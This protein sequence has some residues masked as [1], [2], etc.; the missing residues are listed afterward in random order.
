MAYVEEVPDEGD[1]PSTASTVSSEVTTLEI[2]TET[3]PPVGKHVPA[4]SV[5]AHQTDLPRGMYRVK[6]TTTTISTVDDDDFDET[7]V[8]AADNH[9][10]R[11]IW[12]WVN[13]AGP[14]ECI[15]D[16]GSQV[17]A[18]SASKCYDL[19]IQYDPSTTMPMQ[20][21]NGETDQ[22]LG[23]A[24]D[25]P[26]ELKGGIIVYLQMH[27]VK[28][29]SYDVLLG[30]PFDVLMSCTVRNDRSGRQEIEV[31]CPNSGKR[32]TIPT[33]AR[34]DAPASLREPTKGFQSSRI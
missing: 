7:L 21:A 28:R 17:V 23:L 30:R 25:V 11:A 22:T 24:R 8:V 29:A 2:A 34:G 3:T 26:V 9:K 10:L 12:G 20:S 15:L 18:I 31:T 6:P 19:G 13:D 4:P 27:V 1:P 33:Y 14:V 5:F 16:P 32:L